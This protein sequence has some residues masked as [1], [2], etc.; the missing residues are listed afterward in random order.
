MRRSRCGSPWLVAVLAAGFPLACKSAGDAGAEVGPIC[1]SCVA[2]GESSDFS[3]GTTTAQEDRC[4]VYHVVSE[5]FDTDEDSADARLV[6]DVRRRLAAA[7]SAPFQWSA[8]EKVESGAPATGYDPGVISVDIEF[9]FGETF[10]ERLDPTVCA[11]GYCVRFDE[12]SR[13]ALRDERWL[14]QDFEVRL[15]TSDHA[16]DATLAGSGRITLDGHFATGQ[17]IR[18]GV[19]RA[20]ASEIEGTLRIAPSEPGPAQIRADLALFDSELRGNLELKLESYDFLHFPTY[21]PLV[22]AWPAGDVCGWSS[23]STRVDDSSVFLGG[24]TP[25]ELLEEVKAGTGGTQ[26]ASWDD[27]SPEVVQVSYD[28]SVGANVCLNRQTVAFPEQRVSTKVFDSELDMSLKGIT[29]RHE[30]GV[31]TGFESH[32]GFEHDANRARTGAAPVWFERPRE[33][34]R[35]VAVVVSDAKTRFAS[36]YGT[37]TGTAFPAWDVTLS[38]LD[39]ASC[40]ED[41]CG[42]V[43]R[44]CL[45]TDEYG[46]NAC[47]VL[48][49]DLPVVPTDLPE[50]VIRILTASRQMGVPTWVPVTPGTS[51]AGPIAPGVSSALPVPPDGASDVDSGASEPATASVMHTGAGVSSKP[52]T[53]SAMSSDA[54]ASTQADAL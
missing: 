15:K 41:G 23:T 47:Y 20:Y 19:P 51:S 6:R 38:R 18:G 21:V 3:G 14:R 7:T 10:V 45:G 44:T 24:K 27:G 4:E 1:P 26:S 36:N 43:E 16:I 37:W 29:I 49:E 22:G 32:I 35:T 48:Q 34:G 17:Y 30:T 11:D 50:S 39:W 42:S 52:D 2:G 13:C 9:E 5:L 28:E 46:Y 40:S 8:P 25:R 53:A 54:G 33:D 12:P 31:V